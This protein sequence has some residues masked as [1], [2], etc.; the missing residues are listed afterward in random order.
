[1]VNSELVKQLL[2]ELEAEKCCPVQI[3]TETQFGTKEYFG[4]FLERSVVVKRVENLDEKYYFDI[5]LIE[6]KY[7]SLKQLYTKIEELNV[8]FNMPSDNTSVK[9]AHLLVKELIEKRTGISESLDGSIYDTIENIFQIDRVWSRGHHAQHVPISE[10]YDVL[11]NAKMIYLKY[12]FKPRPDGI[13]HE[14]SDSD[15]FCS[16][17]TDEI[18]VADITL[19]LIE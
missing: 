14:V 1:M 5:D 19:K 9:K 15:D 16:D 10:V 18:K 12:N 2:R 6:G 8:L 13:Y 7:S 4:S 17:E 11:N 3:Q